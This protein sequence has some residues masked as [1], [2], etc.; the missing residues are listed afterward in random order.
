MNL[1]GCQERGLGHNKGLPDDVR[2]SK[3]VCMPKALSL[4]ISTEH[5]CKYVLPIQKGMIEGAG[6]SGWL[7]H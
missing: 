3:H 6:E 5:R 4:G 1:D 2:L 7:L